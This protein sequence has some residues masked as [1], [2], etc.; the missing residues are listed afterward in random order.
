MVIIRV[1]LKLRNLK[2]CKRTRLNMA[3]SVSTGKQVASSAAKILMSKTASKSEKVVA[4]S[5]LT[6][7]K[8]AKVTT[9][10][11][12]ATAAARIL[13]DPKASKEAKS[14]AASAL[15][16]KPKFRAKSLNADEV[17]KAVKS[18]LSKREA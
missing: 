9:G 5:A 18:Y 6:Q 17:Y 13:K 14:V 4:A 8:T 3:K 16:Q 1:G 2:S 7:I 15:T 12:A 11:A 10:K